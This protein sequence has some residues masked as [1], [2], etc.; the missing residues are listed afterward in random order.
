MKAYAEHHRTLA[1]ASYAVK[2]GNIAEAV[3]DFCSMCTAL[4]LELP[5]DPRHFVQHWGTYWQEHNHVR[6]NSCSCGRKRKLSDAH[7]E[8]LVAIMMGWAALGLKGPFSS[9][10][11][12]KRVSP[13][14]KEI[15]EAAGAAACTVISTLKM[16]EPKLAYKKLTVKQKLSKKQREARLR[17]ALLHVRV[18]T[19]RL[20]LVVWVDAK[21]MYMTIK[22]RCGWVRVDD[23]VPFETTRPASKKQPITLRYYI[24][25]CGRAG[26]VFLAFYTGTTGMPANR[27]P[28]RTYLVSS[29]HVQLRLLLGYCCCDGAVDC[30]APAGA[31]PCQPA[32]HQP[33]HLKVLLPCG[34]CQGTVPLHAV[35][36]VGL[37]AAAAVAA[38]VQLAVVLLALHCNQHTGRLQQ[39]QVPPVS[40]NI[41]P[42][43]LIPNPALHC[44]CFSCKGCHSCE[45]I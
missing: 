42:P 38:G 17:V 15:L 11:Q 6:G 37:T 20:D 31:A 12:L 21:T 14:A 16:I 41:H 7:A 23:E 27:D 45:A 43:T 29:T 24:G 26:A 44:M 28:Q 36:Q 5:A 18:S 30:S 35:S 22:T 39:Q 9:L 2:K 13:T 32:R 1:A 4:G 3:A 10:A 8:E 33:H 34:G 19:T 40:P 25:V